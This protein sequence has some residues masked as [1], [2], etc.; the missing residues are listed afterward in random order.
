MSPHMALPPPRA[1]LLIAVVSLLGTAAVLAVVLSGH[2]HRGATPEP[3]APIEHD[4]GDGASPDDAA[5]APLYRPS[6][7]LVELGVIARL[8]AVPDRERLAARV[9][10]AMCGGEEA[11]AAVRATLR[12]PTATELTPAADAATWMTAALEAGAGDA[13]ARGVL[14]LVR[15]HVAPSERH[16]ALRTAFAAAATLAAEAGGAA[17]LI[18]DPVLGRTED[19]AAFAAHA[20]T[21]P[22]GASLIRPDRVAVL[23]AHEEGRAD[24]VVRLYTAGLSRWA[25]P[26]LEIAALPEGAR[27]A[28]ERLLLQVAAEIV[29]GAADASTAAVVPVSPEPDGPVRGRIEPP[30]GEGP[31]AAL[32]LLEHLYGPTELV[33]TDD[34][35]MQARASRAKRDLASALDR[36]PDGK[37]APGEVWVRLPFAIPGGGA[38]S[39]WVRVT[40]HDGQ[41]VTGTIDDDPI[42]AT[43]VARGDPVTRPRADVQAVRT[44]AAR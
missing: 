10:S 3:V 27:A 7:E 21:E 20:V 29:T 18:V 37:A 2:G 6:T 38:E 22:L 42:A 5:P 43:D 24:G 13:G 19:A 40:R 31:V 9:T 39:L 28:G 26:D 15:V 32:E 44:S 8:D 17:G 41:T 35:S 36:A 33:A 30:G 4:G 12:D 11:C 23:A 34:A 25:A 14:T 1:R 16:L